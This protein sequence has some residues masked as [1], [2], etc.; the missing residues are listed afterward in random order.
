MA[1][2]MKSINREVLIGG[3]IGG[4]VISLLELA[5]TLKEGDYHLISIFFFIGAIISG[6]IGVVGTLIVSPNDLRN[7]ISAGVAAPSLLGG[8]LQSGVAT[9][10]TALMLSIVSPEAYAD[11]T[12]I[13]KPVTEIK[14][15]S[16]VDTIA[17]MPIKQQESSSAYK[18]VLRALG[19]K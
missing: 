3:F 6:I 13:T 10:T 19:V 14:D 16:T 11:T 12:S 17:Q 8:L 18:S 2:K 9:T 5:T 15:T 1:G 4:T 7:A